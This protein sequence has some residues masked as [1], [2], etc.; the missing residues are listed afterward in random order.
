[1]NEALVT[2]YCRASL[3]QDSPILRELS[4]KDEEAKVV[5]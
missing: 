3:D 4:Y 1:M 5:Y 2:L